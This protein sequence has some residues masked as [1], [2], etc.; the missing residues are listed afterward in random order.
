M[1]CRHSGLTSAVVKRFQWCGLWLVCLA[2]CR[3]AVVPDAAYLCES[4]AE[5]ASGSACVEG[6]CTSGLDAGF[7]AGVD[8]G[9]DGGTD[10]GAPDAGLDAGADAGAD[11]GVDAGSDAGSDAGQREDCTNTLDD[12]GDSFIDCLDPDCGSA[13][14]RP[15]LGECDRAERCTANACPPDLDVDAGTPCDD[16]NVCTGSD[17]CIGGK[18]CSGTAS[19]ERFI[20]CSGPGV[21]AALLQ[22]TTVSC[23]PGCANWS[24]RALGRAVPDALVQL[25]IW[26]PTQTDGGC[27]TPQYCADWLPTLPATNPGPAWCPTNTA[28]LG[29]RFA[30]APGLIP[31]YTYVYDGG[32]HDFGTSAVPPSGAS[33]ESA[34]PPLYVCP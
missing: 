9:R 18:L 13:V 25:T 19:T 20:V 22:G 26:S 32:I 34:S 33:L 27:M 30:S 12:D 1:T 11:A 8:A 31:L 24:A 4:S 23:P 5:C 21:A 16:G 15:A 28:M 3:V 14:C 29:A 17:V 10:A 2:G 6:E 7:D